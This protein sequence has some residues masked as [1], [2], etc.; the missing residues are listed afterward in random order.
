VS[1]T[2]AL[3]GDDDVADAFF[4]ACCIARVDTFDA[5]IEGLPLLARVPVRARD[6]SAPSI[7]VVT[8]TGGG[9][10]MVVDRLAGAGLRIDGPSAATQAKLAAAGVDGGTGRLV[11][12]TTAGTRYEVMKAALDTLLAAPE[13]DMVVAVVGSS[14]RFHPEL[15]VKP[16]VDSAGAEK[17]LAAFLAPEA[18]DGLRALGAAGVPSFHTPEACAD[19]IMAAFRRRM[20]TPIVALPALKRGSSRML[21][22][23]EAFALL[24]RLGIA[25]APAVAMD[26]VGGKIPALPFPYPVVVKVLAGEIAHKTDVGGLELAVPDGDALVAATRRIAARTAVDRVLVQPMLKG[27]GE[28]L[29]GFRRDPDVGPIVVLAAGGIYTE[30]YRDRSLRLAPV[31]LGEAQAM[32]AEVRAIRTFA[33]YR[34]AARGDLGALA[35]AVVALSRL[36]LDDTVAEAEINPLM[37]MP[38]GQGVVAVDVLV[39]LL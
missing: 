15:A 12:L 28:V 21:D 18:M 31:D 3:A 22:A 17:P 37:V 10:M 27:V 11:D 14:A 16:I 5:L 32:I 36:A 23:P 20:P 38:E 29:I 2:G 6:S 13:F 8:T 9:A 33:G 24:D 30:I 35:R 34:G 39:K 4:A 25:C 7:G 1:H 19:A 26:V